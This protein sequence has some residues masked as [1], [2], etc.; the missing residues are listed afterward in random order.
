LGGLAAR[1]LP[2]IAAELVQ[3]RRLRGG[4]GVSR[5][6]MQGLD[7]NIELVAVRIV[8]HQKFTGVAGDIH[9][10]QA[11]VPAHAVRLVHHRRTDA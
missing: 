1:F 11:D 5:Y 7:R 4:A 8:K 2:L 9:R 6:Q 3:R 10:L